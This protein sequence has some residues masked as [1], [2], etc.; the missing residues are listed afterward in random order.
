M[1]ILAYMKV[2]QEGIGRC[3][4]FPDFLHVRQSGLTDDPNIAL[5]IAYMLLIVACIVTTKSN[6]FFGCEF[7][8][9]R[10]LLRSGST[11]L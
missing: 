2:G 1:E 5:I 4:K 3:L 9:Y 8:Q 11:T 6:H 7:S 10:F